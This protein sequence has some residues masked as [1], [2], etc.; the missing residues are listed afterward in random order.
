MER[1]F[2]VENPVW[3]FFGKLGTAFWL[4]IL[5]TL[6]SIP[7]ITIG[8]SNTAI[9]TVLFKMFDEKDIK[10]TREYFKAFKE[11][12]KRSTIIWIPLLLL[13]LI[14]FADVYICM[15][16]AGDIGFVGAILFMCMEIIITLFFV[17]VF[18]LVARFEN[19]LKQTLI[20][21]FLM[22]IKHYFVTLWII[23][24]SALVVVL[25]IVFPPISLVMPGTMSF[26]VAYPLYYVFH[27]Y[28]PTEVD[29]IEAKAY[30]STDVKVGIKEKANILNGKKS[31]K[32][33][34][35]SNKKMF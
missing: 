24:M 20:N 3:A 17:Y 10:P 35:S 34:K 13:I 8:A 18:P 12:F 4:S 31:D 29:P 19:T 30:G 33:T 22:P 26:A 16:I 2:N 7:I 21:A 1:F 9:F 25:V 14:G 5:W 6:T 23:A 32:K 27:K 28:T 11:N 15:L